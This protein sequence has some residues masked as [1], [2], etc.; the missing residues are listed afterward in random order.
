MSKR[1]I[2]FG[3]SITWGAWDPEGGGWVN[4]LRKYIELGIE[5]EKIKDEIIV[6]NLGIDGD[7]SDKIVKRFE[8]EY[9]NRT[10]YEAEDFIIFDMGTNDASYRESLQSNEVPLK[11]YKENILQL[12]KKAKHYTNNIIFIG[13]T[14]IDDTKTNPIP[15]NK[16]AY[17]KNKNIK[18][19]NL[20]LKDLSKNN[21]VKF[22]DMADLITKEDLEDGLHPNAGGHEKIFQKVKDFLIENKII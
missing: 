12:I 17:Y 2:I 22:I 5:N 9:K 11:K 7:N 1:I 16:D 13:I 4:R 21:D 14:N 3:T 15:W 8:G 18:D 10:I 20:A 19:Y 6:Y